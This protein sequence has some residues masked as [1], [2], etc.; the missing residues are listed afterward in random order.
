[1]KYYALVLDN[2]II[3][4]SQCPTVDCK[5]KSIETNQETYDHIERYVYSNGKIVLDENWGEKERERQYEEI[6]ALR[7]AYRHEHIDDF[8]LRRMRKQANNSWTEE[9]EQAYLLLDAQVTAYIEKN[10]PYP[11]DPIAEE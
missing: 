9:D 7:I 3:G 11:T 2:K 8:T 10:L 6:D 1:M 5:T 4:K